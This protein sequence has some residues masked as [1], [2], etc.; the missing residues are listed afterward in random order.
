[1]LGGIGSVRGAMLGGILLGLMESMG[2][3]YISTEYKDAFA[4][5]ILII[6]LLIRPAGIFGRDLPEKV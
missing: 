2:A 4:F 5:V 1:V 3:A 6:I